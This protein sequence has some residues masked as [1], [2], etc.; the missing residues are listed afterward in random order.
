MR[1]SDWSSDVCSSDLMNVF[2]VHVNRVPVTAEVVATSY[3][4]GRFFNASLDK[5]SEFNERQSIRLR[6]P[7]GREFAVVQIAGLVARRISCHLSQGQ[8]ARV[9]ERFGLIRSDEHT[10]ELQ[11]LMRISYA[12]FCLIK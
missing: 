2:D 10:S 6:L 4:P 11:S 5:A 1:I 3:R 8:M 12:V 9:G 7:D